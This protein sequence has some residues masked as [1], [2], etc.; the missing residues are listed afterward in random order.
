MDNIYEQKIITMNYIKLK[1]LKLLLNNIFKYNSNECRD[2]WMETTI[3]DIK[4]LMR[5]Q[6]T[7]YSTSQCKVSTKQLI[8][9]YIMNT[10]GNG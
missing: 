6:E 5:E 3:D 4:F 7:Q 9:F 8:Y 2:K 1:L 10:K